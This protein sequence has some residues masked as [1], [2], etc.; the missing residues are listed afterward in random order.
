[1]ALGARSSK[2]KVSAG[3]LLRALRDN[4]SEILIASEVPSLALDHLVSV[5]S[6]HFPS[7]DVCLCVHIPLFIR[8]KSHWVHGWQRSHFQMR[9]RSQVLGVR[10][11]ISFWGY[12]STHNKP[13]ASVCASPVSALPVGFLRGPRP[14]CLSHGSSVPLSTHSCLPHL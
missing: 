6:F 14:P 5:S 7:M 9:L 4:V 11:S 3:C 2:A 1:M 13:F 8:V 10:T 12:S